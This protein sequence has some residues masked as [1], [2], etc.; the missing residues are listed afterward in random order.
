VQG[1]GFRPFVYRLAQRHGIRGTVRNTGGGVAIEAEGEAADLAAF[2]TALLAEAPPL[3]R[4]QW[5]RREAMPPSGAAGFHILD[6]EEATAGAVRLPPDLYIC[7]ECVR[8]LHDPANRRHRHPFINCTQCGPR[9]TVITALPYDRRRTTMQAFAMCPDCAREYQDPADRRFHAEPVACPRCGP[10]L[11]LVRHE[12][13]DVPGNEAA[14]AAALALLRTGGIL[15]VK[16]VGGYHLLLDAR[17]EP[18]I[19]RLRSLKPRPHKPLAVMYPLRGADGLEAVRADFSTSDASD[20]ALTSTARPIVLL[21]RLPACTLPDSI[22]PGLHEVGVLLPY[23]PLHELL[24]NDF[25]GPL[26]ATSA[27]IGGEPVLTEAAEVEQRLAQVWDAALHHNRPIARPNDDS[28]L[29]PI[30]GAVRPLRLGRGIA[31]LERS[32]QQEMPEPVLAV[33]GHMKNSVAL[34]FGRRLIIAPHVGDLDAPRSQD[35]F[36]RLCAE[37]QALYR[38]PARRLLHDAHPG[39]ASTR[40]ARQQGLPCHAVW[41]HNAHAGGLA[42]EYPEVRCWLVFTWDGVGLGPDGSLWGGEALLGAPGQ[43]R[44]VAALRGFRLP[45]GEKAAREPWRSA[46][47]L[48]WEAGLPFDGPEPLE[49][50]HL[51]WQRGSNAPLTSAAGRLFDG[52]AALLG[53]CHEASFEGQGPMW[54]EALAQEAPAAVTSAAVPPLPI[55][56][57]AD[58]VLRLDWQPL[59]EELR[60]PRL[61]AAARAAHFHRRLAASIAALAGQLRTAHAFDAVGLTGGVFQN[62]LLAEQ[63]LQTLRDNGLRGHLPLQ[64]PA[65]DGGLCHGQVIEYLHQSL[66]S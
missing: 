53:V 22:A 65:N 36:A 20:A 18:A 33:G 25:D 9:Y 30:A 27:N 59:L 57:D 58:G 47:G 21:P 40:W 52:A 31:P 66:T 19:G 1:V 55:T 37:L 61:P 2:E 14:L 16:G 13:A 48:C 3:A 39:Y 38:Q 7:N 12:D 64:L 41:H 32:L 34:A 42:A 24:L 51:A 54:L 11:R 8:E 63:T 28:V 6:S 43:W 23:S 10:V 46:A 35:S 60:T 5:R 50:L 17:C 45:G 29:R 62:R 49:M 26:V 56:P 4:P 15:A 44:R